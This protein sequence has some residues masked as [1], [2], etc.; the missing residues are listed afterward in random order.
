MAHTSAMRR[1]LR[2][3]VRFWHHGRPAKERLES[4][5]ASTGAAFVSASRNCPN[6]VRT[7]VDTALEATL[8][9]GEET[10]VVLDRA[11]WLVSSKVS[12]VACYV[13][14]G[15]WIAPL[16]RVR[17]WAFLRPWF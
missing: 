10:W 11:G 14:R 1:V 5:A 13:G 3:W 4:V 16:L 12:R 9:K 2:K 8:S 15:F 17:A 7:D 6:S